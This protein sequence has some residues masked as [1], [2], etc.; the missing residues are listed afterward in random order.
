MRLRCDDGKVRRF[1]PCGVNA[2][3]CWSPT[4]AKCMECGQQ[5]G[6]HDLNVLKPMLRQHICKP[7]DIKKFKP[8]KSDEGA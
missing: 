6:C 5:F 3:D 4:E 2:W 8:T 1:R 7:E